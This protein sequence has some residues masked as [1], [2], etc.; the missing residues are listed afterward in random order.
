MAGT[1]VKAIA[2][3]LLIILV[4]FVI[5]VVLF[6]KN[7]VPPTVDFT[8]LTTTSCIYDSDC[9]LKYVTDSGNIISNCVPGKQGTPTAGTPAAFCNPY[10]NEDQDCWGGNPEGTATCAFVG[11]P[12]K[13]CVLAAT[14]CNP[15]Y[16]TLVQA[17]GANACLPIGGSGGTSRPCRT[18]GE[19]FKI[20]GVTCQTDIT[21]NWNDPCFYNSDC[22]A[23]LLCN[24]NAEGGCTPTSTDSAC[25]G[26]PIPNG[27]KPSVCGLPTNILKVGICGT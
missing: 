4:V 9:P 23:G 8:V 6:H 27:T 10:C 20:D 1:F 11:G 21:P 18:G 5:Y 14:N 16:E 26:N 17:N 19:C 7:P 25:P 12:N 15:N 22:P 2:L 3:I 13:V 24:V